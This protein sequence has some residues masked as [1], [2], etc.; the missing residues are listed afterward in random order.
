MTDAQLLAYL[1]KEH[2]DV[3]AWMRRRNKESPDGTFAPC[4]CCGKSAR[5]ST[6][7]EECHEQAAGLLEKIIVID[8]ETT[9][10]PVA[11]AGAAP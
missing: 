4:D 5:G 9:G 2:R 11:P 3:A 8:V 7:C 10:R 1:A 6:M